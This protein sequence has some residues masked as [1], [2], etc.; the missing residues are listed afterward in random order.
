LDGK[1]ILIQMAQQ[2]QAEITN[3]RK[4]F[5]LHQPIQDND[6]PIT[7]TQVPWRDKPT[8]RKDQNKPVLCSKKDEIKLNPKQRSSVWAEGK[9][10]MRLDREAWNGKTRGHKS[11]PEQEEVRNGIPS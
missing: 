7:M 10:N 11:S 1:N 3:K 8:T 2:S 6:Q 5:D 4:T 9:K